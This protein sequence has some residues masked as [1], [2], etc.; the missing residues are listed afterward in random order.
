MKHCLRCR[1]MPAGDQDS[2]GS[3]DL[4]PTLRPV[5]LATR[6]ECLA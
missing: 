5:A 2:G 4:Q 3:W 6:W 1:P